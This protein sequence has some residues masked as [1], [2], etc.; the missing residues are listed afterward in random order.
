MTS[1]QPADSL[2]PLL[3]HEMRTPLCAIVGLADLLLDPPEP[4]P[5][6][7]QQDALR[8]ILR[9]GE[10]LARLVE[11]CLVVWR[12]RS[13]PAA[14]PR[15]SAVAPI[16]DQAIAETPR[17]SGVHLEVGLA[18][19]LPLVLA[20]PDRTVQILVN[21][22]S[23]ALRFSPE[24]GTVHLA[25][26]AANGTVEISVRDQGPGLDPAARARLFE[27][28]GRGRD[29][30]SGLGLGLYLSRLLLEAQRGRL[31]IDCSP[32]HGTLAQLTLPAQ[33]A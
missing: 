10:R 13:A 27:P 29:A 30:R 32:G 1:I 31:E 23:N 17:P 19:D 22:L 25:A 9:A 33:P 7:A 21:L 6:D 8:D 14:H 24:G 26:R 28:F 12:T 5:P 15:A 11:D 2:L 20:D 16:V 3:A 4:L 18:P